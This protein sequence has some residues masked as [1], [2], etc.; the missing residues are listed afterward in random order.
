MLSG[1]VGAF[2]A[3]GLPAWEAAGVAAHVH[4][5]AAAAGRA[6]GMVAAD[7]PEAVSAW[8]SE[9]AGSPPAPA[10]VTV[11]GSRAPR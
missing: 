10:P 1:V 5:R 8:L 6:E 3:R 4:G 2:L 9:R 11:G 7:L